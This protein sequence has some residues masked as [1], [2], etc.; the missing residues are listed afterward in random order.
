MDKT[1][2]KAPIV[3]LRNINRE[4]KSGDDKLEALKNINLDIFSGEFVVI[5]GE[6]GCGKTT[7]LNIIGGM[8]HMTSGSLSVAGKDFSAPTEQELTEYRRT[9][10]GFVF[11]DYHLM[12]NLTAKENVE[13]IAEL[14][15]DSMTA[16]EAIDLVGLKERADNY[17]AQLSGGQ[18]QRVSIARAICK[19]PRL[20]LADEPTAAL[21]FSTSI[22][23]LTVFENIVRVQ[24]TTVVMVTH[25]NE[26]AKMA[27]RIVKVKDGQIEKIITNDNPVKATEL[28]W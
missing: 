28:S 7:I 1:S 19:N 11:Q 15:K 16:D 9:Y 17:P 6:S 26:I 5:L 13:L 2:E 10:L 23:V 4:F 8:D 21:D 22:E 14:S 24:N 18:K 3:T 20:I 12:P 25:N 27:D